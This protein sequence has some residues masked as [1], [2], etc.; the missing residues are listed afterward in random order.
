MFLL[1]NPMSFRFAGPIIVFDF[2]H[3]YGYATLLNVY[4]HIV[5]INCLIHCGDKYLLT[6]VPAETNIFFGFFYAKDWKAQVSIL[7]L[8]TEAVN[9][10]VLIT[11]L[12]Q[13]QQSTVVTSI[14]TFIENLRKICFQELILNFLLFLCFVSWQMSIHN[15]KSLRINNEKSSIWTDPK[16]PK[17]PVTVLFT[18][19]YL[20]ILSDMVSPLLSKFT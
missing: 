15:E 3:N 11:W 10:A 8:L 4:T 19:D 14:V 16:V 17:R 18:Q 7:K 2:K 6:L 13:P 1:L 12:P 5:I 9:I 20:I